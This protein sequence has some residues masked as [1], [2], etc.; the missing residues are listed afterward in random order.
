MQDR[1]GRNSPGLLSCI[2][3]YFV[4]RSWLLA[5][6]L[7]PIGQHAALHLSKLTEQRKDFI[8]QLQ[9]VSKSDRPSL[10]RRECELCNAFGSFYARLFDYVFV[11]K[12]V[13]SALGTRFLFE[14]HLNGTV[15]TPLDEIVQAQA[16]PGKQKMKTT[17]YVLHISSH[18]W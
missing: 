14:V 4:T 3:S 17:F 9:R 6:E 13:C 1:C 2:S 8:V 10:E 11:F 7:F 12:C 16:S 18:L 15:L 5:E